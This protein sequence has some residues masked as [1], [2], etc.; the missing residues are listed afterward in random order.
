ML[1]I[2]TLVILINRYMYPGISKVFSVFL[3]IVDDVINVDKDI[4]SR[5][6]YGLSNISH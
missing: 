4:Y 1:L 6:N 2:L 3:K 5:P